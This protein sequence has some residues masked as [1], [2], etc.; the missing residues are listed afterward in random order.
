MVPREYGT[1]TANAEQVHV[2]VEQAWV[3]IFKMHE[4]GTWPTWEQFG[5][6]FGEHIL[7]ACE[8]FLN[9]LNGEKLK[10]ACK[11]MKNRSAR[12]VAELQAFPLQLFEKLAVDLNVFEETGTWRVPLTR[13]PIS[14]IPKGEDVLTVGFLLR[15]RDM[16]HLQEKWADTVLHG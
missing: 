9:E 16:M 13:R 5:A 14:P 10:N 2:L 8:C 1:H 6:S 4:F 15:V 7:V 11:R 12:R 3:P